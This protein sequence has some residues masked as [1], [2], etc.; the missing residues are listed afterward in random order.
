MAF[1]FLL[2]SSVKEDWMAID[3]NP[4]DLTHAPASNAGTFPIDLLWP[5]ALSVNLISDGIPLSSVRRTLGPIKGDGTKIPPSRLLKYSNNG[6]HAEPLFFS[7]LSIF[8]ASG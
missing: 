7:S 4:I 2:P 8:S 1:P 3:V 6:V 5:L